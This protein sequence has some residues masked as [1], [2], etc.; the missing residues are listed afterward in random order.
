MKISPLD[1]ITF[2]LFIVFSIP[3]VLLIVVGIGEII[4]Q[5]FSKKKSKKNKKGKK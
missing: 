3:A 5:N 2:A 1:A 4:R